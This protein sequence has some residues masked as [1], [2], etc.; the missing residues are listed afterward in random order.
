MV[1]VLEFIYTKRKRKRTRKQKFSFVFSGL[2]I[3]INA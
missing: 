3:K 1:F 2:D